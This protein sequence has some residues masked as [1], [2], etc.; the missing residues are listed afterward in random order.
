MR[1]ARESLIFALDVDTLGGAREWAARL[2]GTVPWIK[3]GS[4][5]FA[6]AGPAVVEQLREAGFRVFLDLKFHDIPAQVRGGCREA[7]RLGASLMTVHASG[8]RAMLEAA[9]EG[10]AE[11]GAAAGGPAA[12]VIAVTVLTSLDE[13]ALREVGVERSPQ[14]QVTALATLAADTGVG[15]IVCSPQEVAAMRALFPRPFRLVT[16]GIRPAGSA[17]DDQARVATPASAIRDG[18]DF[19]VIGRPIRT[20]P[21]PA[22]AVAAI[23]DEMSAAGRGR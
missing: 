3:V 12:A 22:A 11:G 1:D 18:A 13:A 9:A 7:A 16:P 4:R 14:D 19:L 2:A 15:G 8:G 20:A 5:L 6:S 21:D 17:R 10:A 23:L